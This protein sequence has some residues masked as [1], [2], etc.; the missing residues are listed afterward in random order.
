MTWH[1][2]VLNFFMI[3]ER[4]DHIGSKRSMIV[5]T[6]CFII[7]EATNKMHIYIYIYIYIYIGSFFIPSQLY[8][9]DAMFSPIIRST[10]LYLQH[11]VVFTLVASGWCHGWIETRHEWHQPTATGVNI[12]RCCKYSQVLLM[13]GENI[14]RNMQS[15]QGIIN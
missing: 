10:W 2:S 8:M 11:L 14:V 9:F 1:V 6:E 7:M 12:T 5:W 4:M 15:W 13:M 3:R